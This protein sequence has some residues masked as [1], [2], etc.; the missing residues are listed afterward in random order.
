MLQTTLTGV[1]D[2]RMSISPVS[3]RC[4]QDNHYNIFDSVTL[5][6]GSDWW[7][8][9]LAVIETETVYYLHRDLCSEVGGGDQG[10]ETWHNLTLTPALTS[11]TLGWRVDPDTRTVKLSVRR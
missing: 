11:V 7:E 3:F 10:V 4:G 8:V 6:D 5:R 2:L 9:C 1:Q